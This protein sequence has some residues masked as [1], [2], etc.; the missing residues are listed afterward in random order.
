MSGLPT[1]IDRGEPHAPNVRRSDFINSNREINLV[2]IHDDDN[3][4]PLQVAHTIDRNHRDVFFY[5]MQ[6][7]S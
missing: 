5:F 2:S 7:N 1:V 3:C 4:D 6:P